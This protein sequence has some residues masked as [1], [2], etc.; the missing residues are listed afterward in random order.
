MGARVT[1]AAVILRQCG[2]GDIPHRHLPPEH[3]HGRPHLPRHAQHASQGSVEALDQHWHA[4]RRRCCTAR[5]AA[6]LARVTATR[7][8]MRAG[9]PTSARRHGAHLPPAAPRRAE[10]GR[11]AHGRRGCAAA[12]GSGGI[13]SRGR[14]THPCA[15]AAH[16]SRRRL[17]R[18]RGGRGSSAFRRVLNRARCQCGCWPSRCVCEPRRCVCSASAARRDGQRRA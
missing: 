10:R 3:R 6:S 18:A 1:H 15:R 14:G 17:R 8:A 7:A 12:H 11:P 13:S 4:A 2:S 5:P 16:V 9:L